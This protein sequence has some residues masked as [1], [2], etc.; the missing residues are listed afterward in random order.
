MFNTFERGLSHSPDHTQLKKKQK[1]N[2]KNKNQRNKSNPINKIATV[3][4]NTPAPNMIF[5]DVRTQ[6]NTAVIYLVSHCALYEKSPVGEIKSTRKICSKVCLVSSL[7][8][9]L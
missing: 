1:Q 3:T 2:P 7:V 5:L 4:T 9:S 6:H 8:F